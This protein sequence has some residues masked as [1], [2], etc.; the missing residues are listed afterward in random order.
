LYTGDQPAIQAADLTRDFTKD[1][2][3]AKKKYNPTGKFAPDI[4]V[5]G[6]I[7]ELL[8]EKYQV[9]LAGHEG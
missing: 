1:K 6:V 8:P 2:E 9:L 4:I 7:S 5:E 3:A